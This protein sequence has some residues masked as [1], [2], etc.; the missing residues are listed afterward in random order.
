MFCWVLTL[1]RFFEVDFTFGLP[2][3]VCYNEEFV[4]SRFC[5]IH[6]SVFLTDLKGA[7]SRVDMRKIQECQN[8]FYSNGNLQIL[9][10]F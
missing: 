10:Q 7:M 1:I 2:D 8:T 5:C 4:I 6:S 9:V 3:Y